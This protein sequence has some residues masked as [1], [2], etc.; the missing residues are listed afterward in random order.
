MS[1][2]SIVTALISLVFIGSFFLT[3]VDYKVQ[4]DLTGLEFL[5]QTR[6]LMAGFVVIAIILALLGEFAV[7]SGLF[8]LL[9]LAE[10]FYGSKSLRLL[11]PGFYFALAMTGVMGVL[12][13]TFK[14][15]S[16]RNIF[17]RLRAK[18]LPESLKN[19]DEAEEDE[20]EI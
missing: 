18:E 12:F 14:D 11:G 16:K 20:I 17:R 5:S 4:H 1:K 9:F 6:Y 10:L 2:K 13:M 19:E 7:I 15:S 8:V 3:W